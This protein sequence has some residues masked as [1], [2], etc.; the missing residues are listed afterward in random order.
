MDFNPRVHQALG[1][2]GVKVIYGDIS[3][4]ETLLHAGVGRAEILACTIPDT[5]L[6]G[7]TNLK[8]VRQLRERNPD[9]MIV[10]VAEV[11]SEIPE[12]YEAGPCYGSVGRLD[13]A[14][15]LCEVLQAV[16][17]GM[18]D[19]KCAQLHERLAGRA[20]VLA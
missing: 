9:A 11:L 10:T 15:D 14:G 17:C 18:I 12:L 6:K 3:Q 13:E 7:T 16:D 19:A 4:P 5:L 1:R 8:L 2:L 20:E